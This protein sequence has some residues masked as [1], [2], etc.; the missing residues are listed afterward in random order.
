[1][2]KFYITLAILSLV[3]GIIGLIY[4][5]HKAEN[6][7]EEVEKTYSIV[8]ARGNYYIQRNAGGYIDYYDWTTIDRDEVYWNSDIR[9][10]THFQV[11]DHA[12]NLIKNNFN[13]VADFSDELRLVKEFDDFTPKHE[14]L[15]D[16]IEAEQNG[17]IEEA[18]R[19]IYLL[20][21]YYE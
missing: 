2:I 21:S 9:K 10:A 13:L 4:F 7:K 1:M 14:A 11:Q 18:T 15:K 12:E 20:E 3:G 16:L 17:D 5:L 8:E 6:Y 19:L